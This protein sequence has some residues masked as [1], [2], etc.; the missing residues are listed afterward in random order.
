MGNVRI[1]DLPLNT[2]TR[3][4]WV[5]SEI[6]LT[7]GIFTTS[8]SE[9]STFFETAANPL[10]SSS[11]TTVFT[12]SANW[13]SA[14]VKFNLEGRN[15]YESVYSTVSAAS[16]SRWD[17]A[18]NKVTV[19]IAIW[20]TA[21]TRAANLQT[22]VQPSSANWNNVYTSVRSNSANWDNV[23][24]SVRPNS[25]SWNSVYTFVNSTSGDSP[26]QGYARRVAANLGNGASLSFVVTH[27]FNTPAVVVQV[28]N[29]TTGIDYT[30]SSI[31]R[32]TNSVT[33]NFPGPTPP[34]FEQFT[35]IVIG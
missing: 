35:A 18:W 21:A 24:T 1:K 5:V 4:S 2:P 13:N 14:Y 27:N 26:S 17:D 32:A 23:Y 12:N 8:K 25:A 30:P 7:P 33:I 34:S 19:G 28:F 31:V 11:S 22:V 10:W 29:K 6:E 20:N 3:R 16:A 9:L 15:R